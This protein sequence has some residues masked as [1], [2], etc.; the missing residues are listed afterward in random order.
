MSWAGLD[1]LGK[2]L[3]LVLTPVWVASFCL[4]IVQTAN[5]NFG[6][7]HLTA[8]AESPDDHPRIGTIRWSRVADESG[9]RPGD[10]IVRAGAVD[11][12]GAGPFSS[13]ALI[14]EQAEGHLV[15][16]A[17]EREG[18]RHDTILDTSA[19]YPK[20]QARALV[21]SF[22]CAAVGTLILIRAPRDRRS[23]PIYLAAM[24]YA[25]QHNSFQG[26]PTA[27]SYASF[28]IYYASLC[29]FAPLFVRSA[30]LWRERSAAARRLPWLLAVAG[31]VRVVGNHSIAPLAADAGTAFLVLDNVMLLW[32]LVYGIDNLRRADALGRR[33]ITWCA[34]GML[35]GLLPTIAADLAGLVRPELLGFREAAAYTIVL[36]PL[37]FFF[38]IV[39]YDLFDIRRVFSATAAYTVLGVALLGGL[40]LV[41]P[42]VATA[43]S[44]AL[45]IDPGTGQT[46]LSLAMA[47][48]LIPTSRVVRPRIDRLFFRE[49]VALERGVDRLIL[50]LRG[51]TSAEELIR[52]VGRHLDELLQPD[53][54]AFF[55][56]VDGVYVPT[57]AEGPAVPLAV[58]AEGPLSQ[59]LE[60][61]GGPVLVSRWTRRRGAVSLARSEVAALAGMGTAVLIPI[62]R[63]DA[64]VFFVCLGTKGSGDI[65]TATDLALLGRIGE[66]LASELAHFDD[67]VLIQ[68]ARDLQESLR[69]YVPGAVA[70]QIEAGGDLEAGEREVSVLF[71]DI[72]GYTR[73]SQGRE[74]RE[75]FSTVN[76]YTGAV[77][78]VVRAHGGSVVEFNGDGMMAV[79]GAPRARAGTERAAVE[80][81][82]EMIRAV[83]EL[84]ADGG[85]A[86]GE[87]LAVGVG[88]ATGP[89]FVGSIQA[90]DRMI[91]SAIGNTTNLAARLEAKTRELGAS[92][93]IDASTRNAA[94]ASTSAFLVRERMSIRGRRDPIDL[95]VLPL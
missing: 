46:I 94:L 82:L 81:G 93:V 38:A 51:A 65:Y 70:D 40:L 76:R 87:R 49:R 8:A 24:V 26:G 56:L 45:G 64:L 91:W 59:A 43:A 42:R 63:R 48:L 78:Q 6:D 11:L 52:C 12:R 55:T 20:R 67:V 69:R 54:L 30:V 68:Q 37:G 32:V 19:R 18:E 85:E 34:Y 58:S 41:A 71:V 73:L 3:L 2:L 79:F 86:E 72:R 17:Y 62:K 7:A 10:T 92:I 16:I 4:A 77:T 66:R 28:A 39:R 15:P 29:L 57:L 84:S 22:F 23:R 21:L 33:Q 25:I 89:A 27:L 95:Y 83:G 47:A 44:S 60:Q 74:A 88:I 35:I 80:A 1:G 50:D 9:L 53:S 90:A 14:L 75:I 13:Q 36:V 5:G 61:A 31:P